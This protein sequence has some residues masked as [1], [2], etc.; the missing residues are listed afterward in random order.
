MFRLKTDAKTRVLRF[1]KSLMPD[2]VN[3]Q[4]DKK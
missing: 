1:D 3:E 2:R 4:T